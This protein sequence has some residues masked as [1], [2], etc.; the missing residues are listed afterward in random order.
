MGALVR[1]LTDDPEQVPEILGVELDEIPSSALEVN[2]GDLI[3][4][5]F[6]T[7]HGSFNGGVRRRLFTVNFRA[8]ATS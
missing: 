4:T 2:P 1:R 5:N 3:V 7:L 6:K 8:G